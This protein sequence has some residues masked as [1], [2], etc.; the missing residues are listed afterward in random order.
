MPVGVLCQVTV[1]LNNGAILQAT[2]GEIVLPNDAL[3]DAG[4][5]VHANIHAQWQNQQAINAPFDLGE[6]EA[7]GL[8]LFHPRGHFAVNAREIAALQTAVVEVRDIPEDH[9]GD[10]VAVAA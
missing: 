7:T 9:P 5:T 1:L 2:A 10:V 4:A 3:A 6:C 8:P